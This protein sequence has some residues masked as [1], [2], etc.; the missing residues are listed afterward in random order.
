HS[1]ALTRVGGAIGNTTAL[2]TFTVGGDVRLGSAL[3]AATT[4]QHYGGSV[5]LAADTLLSAGAVDIAGALALGTHDLSL[6]TD[7]L[8]LA[9]AA[10]GTGTAR[11]ATFGAGGSIGIA[12]GAGTLQLSQSLLDRFAGLS[13]L[14]I[15][16]SDGS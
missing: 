14:S 5:T 1:A 4:A 16:R 10:S 7:A 8:S 3:V 12:G 2:G 15:G 9:A 13:Q 6:H 11:L